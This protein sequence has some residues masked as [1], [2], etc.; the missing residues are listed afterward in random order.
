MAN[1]KNQ[2]IQSSLSLNIEKIDEESRLF[3]SRSI[4]LPERS[5]PASRR[6]RKR[7]VPSLSPQYLPP[8]TLMYPLLSAIQRKAWV[9]AKRLC[10]QL[11]S[12]DPERTIYHDLYL[13]LSQIT[14]LA[15]QQRRPRTI[16]SPTTTTITVAAETTD[17]NSNHDDDDDG[18]DDEIRH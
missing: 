17:E 15:N 16:A 11:I 4:S 7:V 2:E 1:E 14:N 10:H 18:D 8:D 9:Q 5:T 6:R 13:R 3:W 12:C